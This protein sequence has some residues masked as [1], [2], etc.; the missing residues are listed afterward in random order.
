MNSKLSA[1]L[2]ALV[3]II[4]GVLSAA[5]PTGDALKKKTGV[6]NASS[7]GKTPGV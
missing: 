5:D 1:T 2:P 3:L 7:T 6:Y 4:T